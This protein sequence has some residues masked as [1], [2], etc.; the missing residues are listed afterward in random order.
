MTKTPCVLERDCGLASDVG[1]KRRDWKRES[2][3]GRLDGYRAVVGR[4]GSMRIEAHE[5]S[6]VDRCRRVRPKRTLREEV[7][8][9]HRPW[10]VSKRSSQTL[11][12][13]S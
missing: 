7:K 5:Y 13:S 1:G 2:D 9:R 4:R 3:T 12:A 8:P 6:G 11:L 10:V